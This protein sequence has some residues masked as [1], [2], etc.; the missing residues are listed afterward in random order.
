M[1][2][3][4]HAFPFLNG[5]FH[6]GRGTV[7]LFPLPILLAGHFS[8]FIHA[9]D[10]SADEIL[11]DGQELLPGQGHRFRIVFQNIL[12]CPN[13]FF[14]ASVVF[15]TVPVTSPAASFPALTAPCAALFALPAAAVACDPTCPATAVAA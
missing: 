12:Y 7:E 8:L 14:N 5:R 11:A 6:I 3:G 1:L 2:H 10:L 13:A 4:D 9:V 15:F